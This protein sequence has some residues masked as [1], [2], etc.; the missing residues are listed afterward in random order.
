MKRSIL[1]IDSNEVVL[2]LVA[3]F[4]ER[5]YFF[6]HTFSD[7]KVALEFMLNCRVDQF[8]LLITGFHFATSEI[9][10]ALVICQFKQMQPTGK[11]ICLTGTAN[12]E[13]LNECQL[14]GCDLFLMKPVKLTKLA[15]AISYIIAA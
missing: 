4:L 5:Q 13:M 10:G 3:E 7:P 1:M 15:E 12:Q 2:E 14:A 9:N 11:A 6:M 8:K